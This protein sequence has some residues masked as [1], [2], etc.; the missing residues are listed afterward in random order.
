MVHTQG[1]GGGGEEAWKIRKP[2]RIQERR[3][4]SEGKETI[5][6]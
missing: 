6:L 4:M 1:R 2:V 5:K 3:E